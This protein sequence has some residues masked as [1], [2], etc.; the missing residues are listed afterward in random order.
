[1]KYLLPLLLFIVLAVF[2]AIGLNLNPREIP[3]PLIDKPAPAFNL[4]ILATPEQRLSQADFKGKV[5]LLNVWASWCVS[6]REEHPLLIELAKQNKVILVGLNYK[7]EMPAANAW[8]TKHGNPYTV[9]VMDADGRTGID[10]GVYGVPETFVID[11]RGVVR[12]KHTGP[13]QPGDLEKVFL[14]WIQRLEAENP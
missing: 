3:S 1:M 4:P 10:Y 2:L 9:S 8:L 7:D 12:Y 11:K 6:C 5:W 13:V 14:P